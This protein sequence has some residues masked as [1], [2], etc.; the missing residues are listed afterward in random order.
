MAKSS[1]PGRI[2]ISQMDRAINNY[3][4]VAEVEGR[5]AGLYQTLGSLIT[6]V[7]AADEE[8]NPKLRSQFLPQLQGLQKAVQGMQSTIIDE[9]VTAR[10]GIKTS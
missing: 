2:Q 10:V 9:K 8:I 5:L 3:G 7:N 6:Q 1:M 4:R